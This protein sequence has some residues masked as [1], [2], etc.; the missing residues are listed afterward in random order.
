MNELI[1]RGTTVGSQGHGGNNYLPP[2]GIW[3]AHDRGKMNSRMTAQDFLDIAREDILTAADD[4][5]LLA[6]DD[7]EIALVVETAYVTQ[8]KESVEAASRLGR[9]RILEV[10][11][12]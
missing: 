1:L 6:I 9:L 7:V 11:P 4:H 2:V 5:V 3:R 10:L 12:Q 8:T